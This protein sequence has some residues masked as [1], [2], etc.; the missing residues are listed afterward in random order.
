MTMSSELLSDSGSSSLGTTAP[1][2]TPSAYPLESH[3]GSRSRRAGGLLGVH[4]DCDLVLCC[5]ADR[6]S[7]PTGDHSLHSSSPKRPID[8]PVRAGSGAQRQTLGRRSL[9][10]DSS[11]LAGDGPTGEEH[12]HRELCPPLLPESSSDV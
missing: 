3:V 4:P 1:P 5:V 10:G 9:E 11:R 6:V 12:L 8:P 7:E 2:S